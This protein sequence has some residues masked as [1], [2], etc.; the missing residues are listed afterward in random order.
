MD[1]TIWYRRTL[2]DLLAEPND[3]VGLEGVR[4]KVQGYTRKPNRTKEELAK[5]LVHKKSGLRIAGGQ[6]VLRSVRLCSDKDWR[7]I[8]THGAS[9]H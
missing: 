7:E 9:H 6:A 2:T 4:N 8:C 1:Q 5:C 3:L